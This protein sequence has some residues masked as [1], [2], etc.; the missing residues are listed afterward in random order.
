MIICSYMLIYVYIYHSLYSSL[1]FSGGFSSERLPRPS[2][3]QFMYSSQLVLRG[4]VLQNPPFWNTHFYASGNVLAAWSL[5]VRVNVIVVGTVFC[6]FFL[7]ELEWGSPIEFPL[8]NGRCRPSY[9]WFIWGHFVFTTRSLTRPFV[10]GHPKGK[11]VD[12][13]V[14][15][16]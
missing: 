8:Q 12:F 6:F 9:K 7:A 2:L 13:Q 5:N 16:L 11:V 14:F 4:I 10:T 3:I 1:L 15:I